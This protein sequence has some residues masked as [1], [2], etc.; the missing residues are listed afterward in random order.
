MGVNDSDAML[1]DQPDRH[2]DR[3]PG[4]IVLNGRDIDL[5]PEPA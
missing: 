2:F 1:A 5:E 3:A 4:W